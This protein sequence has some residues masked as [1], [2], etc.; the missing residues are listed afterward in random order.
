MGRLYRVVDTVI[1]ILCVPFYAVVAPLILVDQWFRQRRKVRVGLEVTHWPLM[2]IRED[3][4]V[5]DVSRVAEGLV[6]ISRRRWGLLGR[7]SAP[8]YDSAVEFIPV[9]RFWVPEPLRLRGGPSA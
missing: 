7:A 4:L 1:V 5:V 3:F 8:P 6:G 9:R 2:H